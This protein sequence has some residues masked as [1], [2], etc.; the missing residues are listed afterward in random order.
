MERR[1]FEQRLAA[2]EWPGAQP[3]AGQFWE[4]SL[5]PSQ[6]GDDDER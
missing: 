5:E 2:C 3:T 1:F 6:T 4:S